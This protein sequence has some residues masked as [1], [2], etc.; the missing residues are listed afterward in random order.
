[1]LLMMHRLALVS[2]SLLLLLAA[3]SARAASAPDEGTAFQPRPKSEAKFTTA[4]ATHKKVVE[5]ADGTDLFVETW[6]PAGEG[7]PEKIPTILIMTPYVQAGEQR[8]TTRNLYNVV[9]WFTARGYAV[10]Q[11]HVRG[12]GSSGG[13]LEQT[14]DNQIDDAARVIEFL[15]RDASWTNGSVGMYG[16]SYDAETQVSVAGRGAPAKISYLK[17]IVPSATVAGQYEYSNFDGVPYAGQ[18]ALSNSTYLAD[19]SLA[20]G[21]AP[22]DAHYFERF[23]CVPELMLTSGDMTGDMT[24]TWRVREYRPGAPNFQAASLWVHGLADWN[25]QPITEAG[26]FDRLPAS[27]PHKGLFG[28]WEHN[29]PDKHA[30]VQPDWARQDF[31]EMVTAWYD[32]YLKGLDTGVEQWPAVQV[33]ATDGRWRAEPG[34]PEVGGPAGQLALGPEGTL[35]MPQ[36]NFSTSFVEGPDDEETVEGSRAVFETP[37][38]PA[39]LHLTGQPVLDAWLT[40]SKPD[41]HIVAKL[42]VIG[43]DGEPLTHDGSAGQELGTHA[44]RSL[45]HLDPMP[46]GYFKQ[47]AGK[48]APANTPI[49]VPLRFMPVD[50]VVPA[51]ARLRLTV[52]GQTSWSHITVPSENASTIELHH[53]CEYTSALRFQMPHP[54]APLLNVRETDEAEAGPLASAPKASGTEDGGGMAVAP[55]CGKEPERIGDFMGPDK[56]AEPVREVPATSGPPVDT[57]AGST[58]ATPT[59]AAAPPAAPAKPL[60]SSVSRAPS[61][62]VYRARLRTVLRRGLLI[63][64]RCSGKCSVR[65]VVRGRTRAR[66]TITGERRLRVRLTRSAVKRLR[67]ARN[68][69][70]TVI[71]RAAN[72]RTVRR[73]MRLRR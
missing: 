29:Y 46:E 10:A 25:V 58:P 19:T 26:F 56:P 6:L 28:Q 57:T 35:G 14:A 63:S 5:A 15:G 62:R 1:L 12:T 61:L 17:A 24:E 36:P 71:V 51:G 70:V 4:P 23:G 33:Q 72:G 21:A 52:A 45:R 37:P 73:S 68:V 39:P 64:A 40:S 48:P 2:L 32:R 50:L 59:Q 31:M 13:C 7:L 67:R 38:L 18:A 11:H 3:P 55:V 30:G 41:A 9:A 43:A 20:P 22:V 66:K 27:A 16:H 60:G 44:A 65:V 69:R 49:R 42:Q 8:Y 47:E 54:D 34:W 53:R